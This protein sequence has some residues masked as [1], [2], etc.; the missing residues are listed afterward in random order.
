MAFWWSFVKRF[1][2]FCWPTEPLLFLGIGLVNGSELTSVD[3]ACAAENY[4]LILP[5]KMVL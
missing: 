3:N 4:I 5:L 1:H 2:N